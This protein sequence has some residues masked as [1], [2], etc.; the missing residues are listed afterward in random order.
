MMAPPTPRSSRRWRRMAA[1]VLPLQLPATA[2]ARRRQAPP[3]RRLEGRATAAT[4]HSR[5]WLPWT[6]PTTCAGWRPSGLT[7][8]ALQASSAAG[9]AERR[10]GSTGSS[11]R[12][13]RAAARPAGWRLRSR[14]LATSRAGTH[15][16]RA[17]FPLPRS[18]PP[19]GRRLIYELSAKY[20]NSLLLNF[21]MQKI[22]TQA[23]GWGRGR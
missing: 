19:E 7:R 23:R 3:C 13:V 5:H 18:A 6:K 16:A 14:R 20:Q 4:R 17:S 1:P 15:P 8:S 10:H 12:L 11:R 9:V 22:L 2:A 21:A